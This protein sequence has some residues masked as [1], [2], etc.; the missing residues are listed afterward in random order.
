VGGSKSRQKN[1]EGDFSIDSIYIKLHKMKNKLIILVII[2]SLI[3]I[4]LSIHDRW[5][6]PWGYSIPLLLILLGFRHILK[7]IKKKEQS[8]TE[9][10]FDDN[11][12]KDGRGLD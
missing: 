2:I 7:L 6:S 4:G 8:H 5:G 3:I 12:H 10:W 1:F 11:P 9:E